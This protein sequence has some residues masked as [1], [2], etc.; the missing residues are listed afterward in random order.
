MQPLTALYY[1]R[2]IEIPLKYPMNTSIWILYFPLFQRGRWWF[3]PA[4]YR[5]WRHENRKRNLLS[6]PTNLR[7]CSLSTRWKNCSLGSQGKSKGEFTLN[8]FFV[9]WYGVRG[10]KIS[11]WARE[12]SSYDVTKI[13]IWR[14]CT[15]Y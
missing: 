12:S 10:S 6:H 2:L 14:H 8:D 5:G 9:L 7:G 11:I 4:L 1:V 13:K 3:A 15:I